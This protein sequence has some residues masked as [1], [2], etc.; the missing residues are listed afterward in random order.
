MTAEERARILKLHHAELWPVGTIAT[1]LGRHHDTIER[2][3]AESGLTITK[4][5][6]RARLVD[7]FLP[8]LRETLDK[9]PRLCAS[10]LWS[11]VKARGY[12][13]S[14]SG[15]RAIVRRL[16]PRRQ[17]E[18]FLRRAVL[19]GQEAQVDWA[20]FGTLT[21]GR[22]KRK[23][24]AFVIVL[25]YS[26]KRFVR[27]TLSS[28]MPSFLRGHVEAFAFF[29]AVPRIILY[30][31]LKSAVLERQGDAIRFH[32][33]LLALAGF[34]RFEP[35]P[36][37]PYRP[38]EKGRVER[39]IR[40]VRENFFAARVFSS[41]DD[42]N[43]QARAWC[44]EI[45]SERRVPDAKDRLVE[46]TFYEEHPRML[47]LPGD[48]FPATEKIAVRAGKT[49][50]IRFDKNDYS[51]PF[52]FVRQ[53]LMVLASEEQVRVIDPANPSVVLADHARS[54]DRDQRIE[55]AEHLKALVQEKRHAHQSRGFDRLFSAAPSSRTMLDRIA[56]QGGNLGAVTSGLL[57]L[58]DRVGA[59]WLERA[60]VEAIARGQLHLRAVHHEL[61]R[62]RYE[63]G[64]GP[65]L[66][67]P[68]TSSEKANVQVRPHALSS[69]D[70][71]LE[72]K[73]DVHG[74]G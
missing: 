55:D 63:A 31:N 12:T 74:E 9:Y 52:A 53:E 66:S 14:K 70:R 62:L 37:A 71:L 25:S 41:M 64:V 10:R 17:A 72:D 33:T 26:R 54:Y 69:Y 36:C 21:I 58:L 44:E 19:P 24:F 40:D 7:P 47:A 57:Q 42:L 35:R 45:S 22:A 32:P 43:A 20:H 15:F 51:I 34:Y 11:M 46:D 18:A 73:G 50:Y 6:L 65:V 4:Q 29:G 28:A 1:E 59:E 68:I 39:A 13:G 61:D 16:R 27:F 23:L 48:A 49:P 38:Q 67:V 60:V 56:L 3:L 5:V 30:D 8:F 2:V